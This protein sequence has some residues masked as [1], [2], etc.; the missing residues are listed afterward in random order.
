MEIETSLHSILTKNIL[1]PVWPGHNS[2][3]AKGGLWLTPV[4]EIALVECRASPN[5]IYYKCI[6]SLN[7]FF[8]ITAPKI[9]LRKKYLYV[10]VSTI[11][12]QNQK[13]YG[14]FTYGILLCG[15]VFKI[16]DS[17]SPDRLSWSNPQQDEPVSSC[18]G[19]AAVGKKPEDKINTDDIYARE[20]KKLWPSVDQIFIYL[21]VWTENI[22][23]LIYSISITNL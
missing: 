18:I 4:K 15:N 13:F 12:D 6:R 1:W 20:E 2:S 17:P 7:K 16:S 5:A 3:C 8:P 9:T 21:Y 10:L 11:A 22:A 14:N 19:A 23:K